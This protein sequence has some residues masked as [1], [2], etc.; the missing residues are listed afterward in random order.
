TDLP[1]G[2]YT[3]K[4]NPALLDTAG[5]P[6]QAMSPVTVNF[7]IQNNSSSTGMLTVHF[8]LDNTDTGGITIDS[9]KFYIGTQSQA[10]ASGYVTTFNYNI[11]NG[12]LIES[13]QTTPV[14]P[15]GTFS[16]QSFS[17]QIPFT[18]IQG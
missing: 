17:F 4:V 16:D 2:L 11:Q 1:N 14:I 6:L 13:T 18:P 15:V 8:N 3:I 5:Q 12:T 10:D 7:N 9:L